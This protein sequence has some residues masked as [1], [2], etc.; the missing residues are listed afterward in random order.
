MVSRNDVNET[1]STSH[2]RQRTSEGHRHPTFVPHRQLLV[3]QVKQQQPIR[4]PKAFARTYSSGTTAAWKAAETYSLTRTKLRF[5]QKTKAP[6]G[7]ITVVGFP[8]PKSMNGLANQIYDE[9]LERLA[10]QNHNIHHGRIDGY[11]LPNSKEW[12]DEKP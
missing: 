12:R 8:D 6:N 5:H 4:Q 1:K 9:F 2:L 3:G 10:V 7:Q 11:S